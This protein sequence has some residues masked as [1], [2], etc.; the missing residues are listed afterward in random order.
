[1]Q[2]EIETRFLDINK[3]ELFKK[4]MSLG[5]TNKG[6]E[7]LEEIKPDVI[8]MD[9]TLKGDLDGIQTTEVIFQKHQIPVIYMTAH[10][11]A[12]ILKNNMAIATAITVIILC[13]MIWFHNNGVV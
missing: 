4:L 2:K 5:A 10:K 3:D 8:L 12:I 1:M 9:N 7:K 11:K 6:E 13:T